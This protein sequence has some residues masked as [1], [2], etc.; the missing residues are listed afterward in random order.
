MRFVCFG[1]GCDFV[2]DYDKKSCVMSKISM[3]NEY[4]PVNKTYVF[5]RDGGR[6]KNRFSPVS[7]FF[8][9]EDWTQEEMFDVLKEI[10]ETSI[11]HYLF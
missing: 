6:A 10:G 7:M 8:R 1:H 5:K 3:M 9:E 2:E 4:Y 11:R